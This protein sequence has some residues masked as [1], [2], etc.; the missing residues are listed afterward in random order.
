V[1]ANELSKTVEKM[2]PMRDIKKR[3]NAYRSQALG[4]NRDALARVRFSG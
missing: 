4:L 1:F 3:M 2:P